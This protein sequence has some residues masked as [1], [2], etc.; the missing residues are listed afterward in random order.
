MGGARKQKNQDIMQGVGDR[1]TELSNFCQQRPM[2]KH[3]ILWMSSAIEEYKG[4]F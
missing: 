1:T 4:L 2:G 3:G